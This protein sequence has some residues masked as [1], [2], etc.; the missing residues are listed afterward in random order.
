MVKTDGHLETKQEPMKTR[1]KS[2]TQER[3]NSV[4]KITEYFQ[5]R[6][7]TP[8]AKTGEKVKDKLKEKEKG[9]IKSTG[10][11]NKPVKKTLTP[12]MSEKM[13]EKT[14]K[15]NPDSE[16]QLGDNG[17]AINHDNENATP[18]EPLRQQ[19]ESE[20]ITEAEQ[21]SAI[22]IV[23]DATTKTNDDAILQ[24]LDS[25][26]KKI[27]KLDEDIHHPKLGINTVLAKSNL[28]LDELYGDINGAVSG[29][30]VRL[31]NL[32]A[33]SSINTTKI[34]EMEQ[35]QTRMAAL[36]DENKRIIQE[37]KVM[38]GLVQKV[39]QQTD[40]AANKILD[41]TKRGMEQNLLIHGMDDTL[42][43]TDARAETPMYTAR[44]RCKH[45]VLLFLKE[46]MNID[47]SVEDV[48]KAHR[49]G[50]PKNNKVRPVII[51][52]SYTARDLIMENVGSL[53]GKSNIKTGQSYFIAEQ[54]PEGIAEIKKQNSQR[55]KVLKD[56]NEKKPLDQ[57]SK[58]TVIN[59]KILVN[60]KLDLPVILPPQPSQLF[61]GQEE[62]E[63]VDQLQTKMVQ[64]E[65][66]TLR[67]SEFIALALKVR[68]LKEGQRAYIAAAQR[69]PAA[70]H[71]MLGYALREKDQVL[72]GACNDKEYGAGAK[73]KKSIFEEQAKNTAVFV[74]RKYGG[75]HLGFERFQAI[76]TI[77]KDAIKLLAL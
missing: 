9:S 61:L 12:K 30:K 63:L 70:D 3:R 34:Q 53:K 29:I 31:N 37:L 16:V 51:K 72:S 23:C 42:E 27:D 75:V 21:T 22:P 44:E 54:I 2:K 67:H 1:N 13:S 74:V 11:L 15:G 14:S 20:N 24:K 57:R 58:I 7:N 32:T 56:T 33:Q 28:H 43:R 45:A 47:L 4:S 60:D 8:Q 59:D 36:L 19:E 41:L 69:F 76:E 77:A 10:K 39:S 49:T 55:L 48:W 71:I 73:I 65:P 25:M 6:S 68:S 17:V 50:A 66:L 18:R 46:Q 5:S 38:Q 52:V 62:Q 64:T 35:S 26:Q 40:I